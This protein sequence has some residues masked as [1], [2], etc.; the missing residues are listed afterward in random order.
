MVE[1]KEE[2][3]NTMKKFIVG[4]LLVVGTNY[5]FNVTTSESALVGFSSIQRRPGGDVYQ[6]T[7][8][9]N[10]VVTPGNGKGN[11]QID[12]NDT[13][14]NATNY[15][16]LSASTQT[17]TGGII[18]SALTVTSVVTL[19]TG[20]GRA[21]RPTIVVGTSTSRNPDF[22]GADQNV[23][24]LAMASIGILSNANGGIVYAQAGNYSLVNLVVPSSITIQFED[25]AVCYS[26]TNVT[27]ISSSGTIRNLQ[28]ASNGFANTVSLLRGGTGSKWYDTTLTSVSWGGGND[29]GIMQ[30][31]NATNVYI[32]GWREQNVSFNAGWGAHFWLTK[33]TDVYISDIFSE[34]FSNNFDDTNS[35]F[36]MIAVSNITVK[37]N[38]IKTNASVVDREGTNTAI[39]ATGFKL[40]DTTIEVGKWSI[41]SNGRLITY[42]QNN[43]G[44][45]SACVF[46]NIQI[47]PNSDFNNA[48]VNAVSNV[49]YFGSTRNF[50]LS[51][52]GIYP[53]PGLTNGFGATNFVNVAASDT[54]STR[55]F[56]CVIFTGGGG[57]FLT[58]S[59]V[60]TKRGA[61]NWFNQTKQTID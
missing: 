12:A 1:R 19:P 28:I 22:V 24:N 6:I 17:K 38:R 53:A 18:V 40:L 16:N 32:K 54:N 25:G 13:Q 23:F 51:N 36:E 56:D 44:N 45:S 8:G 60:D 10:V 4:F 52:I 3:V 42:S 34:K 49:F 5:V 31:D 9:S 59:G 14:G 2:S 37:N 21:Y 55:I 15:F 26:S 29:V 57:S 41:V 50:Q 11:V 30:V 58:D 46:N 35:W 61:G 39:S 20:S 47:Y 27:M 7:A 48:A 33:C 43:V